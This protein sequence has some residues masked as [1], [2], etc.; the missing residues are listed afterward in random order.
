[1][2]LNLYMNI[3][4]K[5]E[6]LGLSQ[7]DLAQK[8]GYTNRSSIAKIEKG[9]VDLPQTKIKA[10]AEALKTTPQELMGWDIYEDENVVRFDDELEEAMNILEKAGYFLSFS[11]APND[12]VIIIKNKSNEIIACMHDYELVNKYESLARKGVADAKLLAEVDPELFFKQKEAMMTFAKS[13]NIQYYEKELL[14]TFSRLSNSNKKKV[15]NYS[16]N[17]LNIQEAE[18][19]Q[20]HLIPDAAQQRTDLSK[21]ELNDNARNKHDDDIMDDP[22]F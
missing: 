17:L 11:D 6:E 22:N 1:M 5:R 8:T 19:E 13:W 10:F 3:K 15:I 20:E 9:L 14:N 7:D 2:M 4:R 12:D 18:A 16:Q 21:K